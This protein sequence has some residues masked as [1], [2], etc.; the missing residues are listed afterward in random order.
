[1]AKSKEKVLDRTFFRHELVR[2]K[3]IAYAKCVKYRKKILEYSWVDDYGEFVF[4]DGM[5][6]VQQKIDKA[7][8]DFEMAS[9]YLMEFDEMSDNMTDEEVWERWEK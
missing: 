6:K 4:L 9:V 8:Q 3:Q 1:M 5:G 7:E 2:K